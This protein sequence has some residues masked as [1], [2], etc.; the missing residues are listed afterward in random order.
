MIK[1]FDQPIHVTRPLL[2][3]LEDLQSRLAEV[4][5][6]QWLTN[7]GVQH[8]KLAAA[9]RDYLGVPEVSLFNN[10]TIALLAAVRALGISGEVITTPFTF[11]APTPSV[12]ARPRRCS[13]TSIPSI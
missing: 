2:P 6:A 11:P 1:P 3:P 8:E 9:I 4:W 12:G 10:G 13:A 5:A 7:A